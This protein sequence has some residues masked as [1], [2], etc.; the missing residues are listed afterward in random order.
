MDRARQDVRRCAPE[1]VRR[2]AIVFGVPF[3]SKAH[4]AVMPDKIDSLMD[5]ALDVDAHAF[6]CVFPNLERYPENGNGFLHPGVMV[7]IREVKR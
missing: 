5:F 4:E 6:A 1:G 7:W 3:I 2:L